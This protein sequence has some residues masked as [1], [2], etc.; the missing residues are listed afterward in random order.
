MAVERYA[1]FDIVVVPFPY[2]DRLAEKRRPALVISSARLKPFDVVWVMMIT[3][4]ANQAWSCDVAID[5]IDRAGL[6]VASVIRTAKMA[7]IDPVRIERIAG[8]LDKTSQRSVQQK[9]RGFL[10][11]G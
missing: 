11:T 3:S 10:A 5:D 4:A 8:R 9:L 7:C 6:S 2:A 1:P